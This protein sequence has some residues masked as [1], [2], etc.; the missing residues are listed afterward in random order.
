MKLLG[1]VTAIAIIGALPLSSSQ[2]PIVPGQ[3][4]GRPNG[5]LR[6]GITTIDR[7]TASSADVQFEVAARK[8]RARGFRNQPRLHVGEWQGD[9]SGLNSLGSH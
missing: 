1:L 3:A 7:D 6:I 8:H 2:V 5:G 4:W 9:V